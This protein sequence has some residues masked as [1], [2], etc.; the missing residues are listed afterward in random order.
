MMQLHSLPRPWAFFLLLLVLTGAVA[1]P[2]AENEPGVGIQVWQVPDGLEDVPRIAPNQTPNFEQVFETV[3]FGADAPWAASVAPGRMLKL[4][5]AVRGDEIGTY[6]LRVS[7]GGALRLQI[8]GQIRGETR[9][10][11]GKPIV[12]RLTYRS[13]NFVKLWVEQYV[14]AGADPSLRLEWKAPG[15]QEWVPVPARAFRTPFDPTRVTSPGLK[16]LTNSRRPGDGKP[17][18]GVHPSYT[19]S[20]IRPPASEPSVGAMAFTPDG[21]LILGTFKPV[22]RGGNALPDIDSK[23]PDRLYELKNPTGDDPDTHEL[24][25]V[26]QGLYEPSGLCAVGDAIYVSQRRAVTRLTDTDG[27]GFY[28]THHDV[29]SGWEGWNYH[30][31]TFGLEHRDGKLYAALST[32]MA[33]PDWEGMDSNAGPNGPMRGTMLEIDLATETARVLAGGLRTPNT[34]ALGPGGDL[35][36]ADNQGT[37]FPASVLSHVQD[38]RFYGHFNRTNPVPKLADRYP[39]GGHPSAFSDELRSPPVVYLPQNEFINS[40]TKALLI[41]EGRFAGQMLLGEITSGGIRRVFLEKVNGQWQ[42]A[43]F[44]FTQGL[45]SGVNRLA[46]GPDGALYIG[47]IGASGGWAWNNTKFGLQR[48]EPN[49][50]DT[51]EIDTV[52]ATPEGFHYR[53]TDA[54]DAGWLADPAHYAAE[55]WGYAPSHHYG[56]VKTDHQTLTVTRAT[57]DADGRGVRIVVPGLKTG[58]CVYLRAAPTSVAGEELWSTEAY[59]TLNQRPAAQPVAGATLNGVEVV[60]PGDPDAA[61]GLGVL[62]PANAVTLI[63]RSYQGLMYRSKDE[64]RGIATQG[65]VDAA[66]LAAVGETRGI[67]L[68]IERGDL[69][70]ATEFGDHRLHVEWN[71]PESIDGEYPRPVGN[72]GVYLQGIYEIQIHGM[73]AGRAGLGVQGAGAIYTFKEPDAHVTTGPNT[74]QSYDIWFRAARF[75]PQG[76]KLEDARVTVYW[77]GVLVHHD[78]A[79]PPGTGGGA[80]RGEKLQPGQTVHRGPVVLQAHSRLAKG[81]VRLRNVWAA[82]LDDPDDAARVAGPAQP[83]FDGQTLDGWAPRGGDGAFAVEDGAIVGTPGGAPTFLMTERSFT[84]FELSYEVRVEGGLNSGVQIR[85]RV[86]GGFG[87]RGGKV[88]GLQVEVDP[89]ARRYSGGVLDHGGRGWLNPLIEK[90]YAR[91][92]WRAGEWNRVDVAARG[93]LIRTWVNGVPAARLMDARDASGRIGLE[94]PAAKGDGAGRVRFRGLKLREIGPASPG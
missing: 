89:S 69:R 13:K 32:A 88:R 43:A 18:Q 80:R 51:F 83:L 85:S 3:A 4:T 54:V 60:R 36:Y 10:G 20:T 22:Q 71:T 12:S 29:A 94:V 75:S 14:P 91:R 11:E 33:P 63:G 84:D 65:A 19:L 74:W 39:R 42:G 48:L 46:W 31:F 44:R 40:P 30:Q 59:Y 92:A 93:P 35:F 73:P 82:P 66:A 81:P 76:E 49:G 9:V 47:G 17:V 1:A 2:A 15:T 24:V 87:Q 8:W 38:G 58:R 62:P 78:V 5:A 50:R 23:Q 56:G 61:V 34:V 53:F 25:P 41:E 86:A 90:P 16:R 70:T 67:E 21:R 28:E 37:W 68:P 27:D 72:S 6:P 77:N 64:P 55:Q 7:G 45:E 52:S 79:L 57:P 26:A